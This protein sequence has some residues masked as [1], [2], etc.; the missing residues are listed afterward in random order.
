M[1]WA[2]R[3][4]GRMSTRLQVSY[5]WPVACS[6]MVSGSGSGWSDPPVDDG[7]ATRCDPTRLGESFHRAGD[8]DTSD[9]P[10]MRSQG[11]VLET[12]ADP[13]SR[14]TVN[15]FLVSY[16]AFPLSASVMLYLRAA[17]V[18]ECERLLI[19][20]KCVACAHQWREVCLL[21]RWMLNALTSRI[22]QRLLP[23]SSSRM[24]ISY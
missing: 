13:I 7:I 6:C 23:V 19:C 11:G 8:A 22:S 5:A 17:L 16:D 18:C 10:E 14:R 24:V 4:H 15:K 21:S 20:S 2:E 12:D 1:Y 9:V 3:T